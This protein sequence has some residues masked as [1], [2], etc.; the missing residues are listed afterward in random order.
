LLR[1]VADKEEGEAESSQGIPAHE[2]LGDML[3]DSKH[4]EEALAE[5]EAS[6]KNDPGRFDSL[7]GAAQAAEQAG[8]HDKANDYYSKLVKN[9]EGA[10]SE[11][12]EL[13]HARE[14]MEARAAKN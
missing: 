4:Y 5:Y 3:L 7:Y 6:L 2:M 11:R 10:P 8:K 9:C 1:T 14:V 13:K 12:A